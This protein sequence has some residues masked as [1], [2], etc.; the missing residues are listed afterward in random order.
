MHRTN[1]PQIRVAPDQTAPLELAQVFGAPI[2]MESPLRDG[3]LREAALA[4]D[5]NVLLFE[6]GQGLRF[7]EFTVRAGVAGILRV[8]RHLGMVSARGVAKARA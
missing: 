4:L 1:Y 5:T 2:I 7:D 3:S 6:G 8:L